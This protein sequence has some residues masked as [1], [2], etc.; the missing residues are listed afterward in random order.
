[1]SSKPI[2]I[3]AVLALLL[4]VSCTSVGKAPAERIDHLTISGLIDGS[5][6]FTFTPDAV[7]WRHLH[8]S[9]PSSMEFDGQSWTRLG[10]TPEAWRRFGSHDLTRA[11]IIRRHGRDVIAL[12]PSSDGFILYIDDSP[13]GAGYYSATIAIPR[14]T[15]E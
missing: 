12:E 7:K 15:E 10:K 14:R 11:S 8:W 2:A 5:E 3:L 6:K 1:M 4:P 13:N 9:T